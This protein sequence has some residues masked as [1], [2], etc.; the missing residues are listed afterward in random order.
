LNSFTTGIKLPVEL[1]DSENK[2]QADQTYLVASETEFR[3]ILTSSSALEY[4]QH[5]R[6]SREQSDALN[7][8]RDDSVL[9]VPW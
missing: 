2:Q 8:G 5:I 9:C 3:S 6:L 7:V 1:L 4:G